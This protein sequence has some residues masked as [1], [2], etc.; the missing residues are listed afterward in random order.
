M[1]AKYTL[2][3]KT[4]MVK[5]YLIYSPPHGGSYSSFRSLN[6]KDFFIEN[7]SID[8]NFVRWTL[9]ELYCNNWKNAV[10]CVPKLRTYI[11]YKN[12]YLTEPYVEC[13]INRAHR[14]ALAKFRCG[15]LP[16]SVGT[17]RFN[18]IPLEFRLCVFCVDNVVEDEYHFFFSC[19]LYND[20][21]SSLFDYLRQ[22]VPD[23]DTL[24]LND[25]MIYLMSRNA[26]RKLLNLYS[27]PLKWDVVFCIKRIK[28]SAVMICPYSL[29]LHV[30]SCIFMHI[31]LC[32]LIHVIVYM[33]S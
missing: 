2:G 11:L 4:G 31:D 21:R 18:A 28:H 16:V 24:D 25:K 33:Y 22:D 5:T 20:L 6:C 9:H 17:G 29:T 23:F 27:V 10:A 30:F 7:H 13:D 1:N 26:I 19:N 32:K 12:E 14:S 15:I 3:I 8:L